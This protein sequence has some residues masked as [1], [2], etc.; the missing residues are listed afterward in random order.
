MDYLQKLIIVN[1]EKKSKEFAERLATK[2][3][4]GDVIAFKGDLGAGKSFFCRTIIKYLCGSNIKVTSPTFNL[5]Q[6]YKA[7]NFIIYHYD[8]YRIEHSSELYELGFEEAFSDNVTLIEWPQIA[9]DLLPKN[10]IFVEIEIVNTKARKIFFSYS[11][12]LT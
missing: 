10:T 7:P 11:K 9:Y 3:N 2:I 1:S 5:L 8:L 12:S 4:V 6:T